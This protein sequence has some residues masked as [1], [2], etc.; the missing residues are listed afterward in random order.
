LAAI[1]LPLVVMT[2]AAAWLVALESSGASRVTDVDFGTIL[3]SVR[4]MPG[5]EAGVTAPDLNTPVLHLLLLPLAR[6]DPRRA[7][8]AWALAG[9]ASAFAALALTLVEL[10]RSGVSRFALACLPLAFLLFPGTAAGVWLGQ[11]GFV[12]M[13]PATLAWREARRER[14]VR[15][16]AWLGLLVALK[17]LWALFLPWLAW[18]ERRAFGSAVAAFGLAVAAG[19]IVFGPGSY[20]DWWRALGQVGWIEMRGN[21]SLWAVAARAFSTSPYLEYRPLVDAPWLVLPIGLLTGAAVLGLSA[22]AVLRGRSTDHS[23]AILVLATLLVSPLGWAYYLVVAAAPLAVLAGRQRLTPAALL[24][25]LGL[26]WPWVWLR[27]PGP[28]L[29]LTVG[30]AYSWGML[31]AWWWIVGDAGRGRSHGTVEEVRR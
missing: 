1:A 10:R 4:P 21:A 23:F 30:S 9:A 22:R 26:Y 19:A 8:H 17:P 11:V 14:W 27:A 16:G 20:A 15:A 3:A 6:L 25:C 18:R 24:A 5:A 2:L 13:L 28:A 31:A 7:F 12:L 29:S